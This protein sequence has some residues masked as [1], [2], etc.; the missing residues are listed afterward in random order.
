[1]MPCMSVGAASMRQPSTTTSCVAEPNAT[2]KVNAAVAATLVAGS[3][4]PTA[5]SAS[6]MSAWQAIIHA[7]R[8]PTRR[9]SSGTSNASTSGDQRNLK[10]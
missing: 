1:M 7:R 6:A 10:L 2:T 4:K 9:A 5:T 8:R 3:V